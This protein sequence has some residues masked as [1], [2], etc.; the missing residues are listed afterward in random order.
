VSVKT[1]ARIG[2]GV[3]GVVILWIAALVFA[4]VSGEVVTLTT[5]DAGGAPQETPLWVVDRDG[6]SWL[7]AG[8]VQAAWLE[9]IRANP[10]IE[11]ARAGVTRV[12]RATLVPEATAEINAQMA[13]KY[14]VADRVV[15]LL[16]PGSRGNSMAVRLDPAE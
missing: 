12:Y 3:A 4:S 15:G 9:R 14:G 10:R 13:D 2:I 11:I 5:A 7:R 8:S 1:A 16:L 6:L